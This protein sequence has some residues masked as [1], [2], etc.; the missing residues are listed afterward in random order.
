MASRSGKPCS[1]LLAAIAVLAVGCKEEK[2]AGPTCSRSEGRMIATYAD[3]S[4]IPVW[5]TESVCI[6]YAEGGGK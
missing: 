1:L 6:E 4:K 3:D 2:R 5:V